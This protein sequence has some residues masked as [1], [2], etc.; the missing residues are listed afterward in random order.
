LQLAKLL[1][2]E[3]TLSSIDETL[4]AARRLLG[5]ARRRTVP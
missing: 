3:K 1:D 4:G 2:R 5:V